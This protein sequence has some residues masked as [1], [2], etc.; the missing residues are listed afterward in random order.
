[1]ARFKRLDGYDVHFLTGTD[2]H[3]QKVEKA[4]EAAGIAPQAFT[5]K[6]SQSFRDLIGVMNYS[7][8]NFIRTTEKRHYV[9][10]QALWQKLVA[11][12][13]IYLGKYA[14]WYSVRDEAFYA[15]DETTVGP[16]GKRRAGPVANEVEWVEEPSYFFKLS[17]WGD[18]LLEFYER[19][20]RFIAPESRRNEIL[21]FVKGGL[22]DLS[23]SAHQFLMGRAGAGRSQAH[24]VRVAGRAH[25][26]H[27]RVRLSR[28]EQSAVAVLAGRRACRGQGHHPLPLRLLAGLPDVGRHR[29]APARLRLG[30]VD[31]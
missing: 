12:G 6:V 31:D 9:S 11:A 5:D 7:P 15:E 3:G 10:C 8:D 24:H 19:N 29:A 22:Q 27:Y 28:R 18:R 23:V 21:S 16:D 4:A 20:P 17:A 14:G 13:D 2:E 30:L 25:Q 1:M 26:L